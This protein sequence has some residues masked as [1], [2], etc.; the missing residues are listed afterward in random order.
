MN[1]KIRLQV[2]VAALAFAG[3]A[4]VFLFSTT[5][6]S[7]A[8]VTPSDSER[9]SAPVSRSN[10][11]TM[12]QATLHTMDADA[13]GRGMDSYR[14]DILDYP[15]ACA[16]YVCAA[17]QLGET[18]R[19]RRAARWLIENGDLDGDGRIGW[20]L[21]FA[22]DAF[23]DGSE[24]P[25]HTVY[26]ITTAWCVRALLDFLEATGERAYA[27]S[28]QA[29]LD[30]Y[31]HC[32]S[33]TD[34]G[35]FYWYSQRVSDAR[36]V[37]NV[38]SMLAG[39]YARAAIRF[40]RKDFG[41]MATNAMAV[42][43]EHR[44]RGELGDFWVY[45]DGRNQPNDAVHAAYTVQGILD[46]CAHTDTTQVSREGLVRYLSAFIQADG[47]YEFAPHDDLADSRRTRPARGWAVGMLI[48]TLCEAGSRTAAVP[49]VE[50]LTTYEFAPGKYCP[51]LGQE[52]FSPRTQAHIAL[53][54]ARA[55]A[56]S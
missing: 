8:P 53:G 11:V 26:G 7:D 30:D 10:L 44:Q 3:V 4:A 5:T 28:A 17:L 24:N 22:W 49:A 2:L 9:S 23:S 43:I 14:K 25:A 31:A 51:A 40:G 33:K 29:A 38:N 42:V 55:G 27:D 18:E 45:G 37:L 21:P 35:G 19:A 41:L 48:Y 20:G 56:G 36:L 16:I 39:Q 34:T 13:P 1:N 50:F 52:R 46:F 54:L 47:V 15:M 32:F 12:A 6:T